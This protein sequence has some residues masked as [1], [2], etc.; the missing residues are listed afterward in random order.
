M[1]KR[2]QSSNSRRRRGG[3]C[4]RTIASV[5]RNHSNRRHRRRH[6]RRRRRRRYRR[7]RYRSFP[8]SFSDS[9][10]RA[11]YATVERGVL[12]GFLGPFFSLLNPK[13][14]IQP[15]FFCFSRLFFS[16]GRNKNST[17]L[18]QSI[19]FNHHPLC[20]VRNETTQKMKIDEVESTTK[21]ARVATHTHIKV[22]FTNTS[23]SSSSF[24][25][26]LVVQSMRKTK[27]VAGRM[28]RSIVIGDAF[29]FLS[30]S[31]SRVLFSLSPRD[32]TNVF[33]KRTT[34]SRGKRER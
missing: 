26:S 18:S 6:R 16:S 23:S 31:R 28:M 25:L 30:R 8:R 13:P 19:I 27:V 20:C 2:L 17:Q 21:K 10:R 14:Y 15:P 34:G 7:R 9:K 5:R 12:S 32:E 33:A 1:I 24:S 29:F 3:D 4:S 22:F 11:Y